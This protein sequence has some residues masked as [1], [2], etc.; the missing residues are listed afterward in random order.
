MY[1]A[2]GTAPPGTA[3]VEFVNVPVSLL[4]RRFPSPDRRLD[5][6]VPQRHRGQLRRQELDRLRGG[7]GGRHGGEHRPVVRQPLRRRALGRCRDQG[8]ERRR[9]R[10]QRFQPR[11]R[12][13]PTQIRRRG[14]GHRRHDRQR[15]P[16][17][18]PCFAFETPM[19][20]VVDGKIVGRRVDEI[21]RDD[22]VLASPEDDPNGPVVPCRVEEVFTNTA[23]VIRLNISG[24]VIRTTPQHRIY[25]KNRG[26]IDAYLARPGDLFRTEDNRW[27]PIDSIEDRGKVVPVYN[28]RIEGYHTYFVGSPDWGFSIWAHNTCDGLNH[29]WP[30]FMGSKLPNGSKALTFF[31]QIGHI[32]IHRALNRFLKPLGMAL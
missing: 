6:A 27:L 14:D 7:P 19:F 21:H 15:Q 32:A 9:I 23:A 28:F 1:A 2:P 30:K 26:W 4:L 22:E 24:R 17:P 12:P 20:V 11:R 18:P 25:I 8:P 5:G 10:G 16:S 29:Y 13:E 3:P 31:R